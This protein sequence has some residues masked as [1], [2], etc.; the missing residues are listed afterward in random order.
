MFTLMLRLT[1]HTV[2]LI[3]NDW[4]LFHWDTESKK[5]KIKHLHMI[6]HLQPMS[7]AVITTTTTTT[8]A[9]MLGV[10][11]KLVKSWVFLF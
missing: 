1:A 5:K 4:T 3:L 7:K 10:V 8:K 2:M 6:T 9:M 11:W